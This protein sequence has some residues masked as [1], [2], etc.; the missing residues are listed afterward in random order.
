MEGLRDRVQ[1]LQSVNIDVRNDLQ[2]ARQLLV[3]MAPGSADL[4]AIANA[5]EEGFRRE[6]WS[7]AL[8]S[9]ALLISLSFASFSRQ[10]L[11]MSM[12]MLLPSTWIPSPIE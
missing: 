2:A 4:G 8:P 12:W 1:R 11:T 6:Y 7:C 10:E 5:L 3:R 9:F